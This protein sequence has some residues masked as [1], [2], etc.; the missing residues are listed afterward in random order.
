MAIFY[1][2]YSVMWKKWNHS[3]SRILLFNI[4]AITIALIGATFRSMEISLILNIILLVFVSFI[5]FIA[6]Q[7][8]KGKSK[9]KGL[10]A[11]YLLL[12]IFWILNVIDILIPKFLELYKLI[13]YL[14][15]ILLFMTILYRVLKKT[16]N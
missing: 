6:Y 3:S 12:F 7:D 10:F 4:I 9:G 1:L 2:L 16:G 13:I 5:L 8:S 14:A 15:S 11:I